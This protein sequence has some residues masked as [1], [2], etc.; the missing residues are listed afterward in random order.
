MYHIMK[1]A[2]LSSALTLCAML[3][4]CVETSP[5]PSPAP[6]PSQSS[7]S[8]SLDETPSPLALPTE[9][10]AFCGQAEGAG[11][12]GTGATSSAQCGQQHGLWF[13]SG[14]F[15]QG[16]PPGCCC[17]CSLRPPLECD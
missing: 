17:V 1:S 10:N 13:P 5:P 15:F 7:Q 6:E 9:C 4:G 14:S 8:Q 16:P 11:W 12:V 2:V 3:V